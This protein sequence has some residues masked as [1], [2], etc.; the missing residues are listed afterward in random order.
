MDVVLV[1]EGHF[2]VFYW[3]FLQKKFECPTF[4][5][6]AVVAVVELLCA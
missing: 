3:A 4:I 2:S 5:T 6:G 1:V